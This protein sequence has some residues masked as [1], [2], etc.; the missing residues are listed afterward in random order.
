MRSVIDEGILVDALRAMLGDALHVFAAGAMGRD[1]MRDQFRVFGSARVIIGVL[2]SNPQH[3]Q[4]H[5]GGHGAGL[6]NML[7]APSAAAVIAFPLQPHHDRS[8]GYMAYALG[9][10]YWLVPQIRT[11]LFSHYT[12][13]SVKAAAVL[14]VLQHVLERHQLAHLIQPRPS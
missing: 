12:M 1:G 10:D 9:L 7:L 5:P 11:Y 8:F 14:R 6:T 2:C 3:S 4:M 13:D